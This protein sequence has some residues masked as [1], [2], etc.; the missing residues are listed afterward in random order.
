M[1]YNGG[2]AERVLTQRELNRALLARQLL[3]ERAR[4]GLPKALE[5][6]GGIQA[7][8]A[9]SMYIGLWSRVEGFQRDSLDRALVRRSVAQGTLMRLTIHLVSASDWWPFAVATREARRRA[10]L[11]YPGHPDARKTAAA[12]RKVRGKI[13]DGPMHRKDIEAAADLER[14]AI[15]GVGCWLDMVRVPPSGTW[16]RRRADVFAAAEDWLG[17][18]SVTADDALDRA[19]ASY[20]RGFGPA[21][22]AEIA[23]YLGLGLRELEPALGR[24]KLR[25]FQDEGGKELLDLP[26]APLPDPATPA[27]VRFLPTWDATLL[28]HARRTGILPE[29][30]RSRVFSTRT[31]QSVSTFL[32]DG[33]VAGTWRYDKGRVKVSPFSRLDRA[34][35]R[36]VD[37]EAQRLAALHADD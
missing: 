6:I 1:R 33:A 24:M 26:R 16:D 10:W 15:Y 17:P 25:R 27:P 19:V 9:P 14:S 12:A 29:K 22:R 4:M 35:R 32:V 37:D 8:Y 11:R 18:E 20:L 36:A 13:A 3:L 34:T 21:A 2:V 5:R 7:Q 30:Y 31:P 23:D 28:A